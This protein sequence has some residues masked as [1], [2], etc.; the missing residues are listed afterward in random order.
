MNNYK[1]GFCCKYLDDNRNKDKKQLRLTEQLMN[2]KQTTLTALRKLS[3]IDVLDKITQIVQHNCDTLWRQLKWLSSQP[4]QLRLFRITS[5]FVPAYT[6]GEF[7]WVFKHDQFKNII[8]G[9]QNIKQYAD[10]HNIRL[11]SHPGQFTNICSISDYVVDESILELEYHADLA[12][13]MGYGDTWHSSG[14]AIN[15]HANYQQD[16]DLTR[17]KDI[18]LN[19]V[20]STVRNLITLENDEFCCSVDQIISSGIA[21]HVALVLDIHHHFIQSGEYIQSDDIRAKTF[22][23]SWKSIRP[24]MHMSTSSEMILTEH[25]NSVLPDRTLLLADGYNRKDLRSHSYLCWNNAVNHWA[26][27]FL[28]FS[29]I[30]VE[31]KAKNLASKQLYEFYIQSQCN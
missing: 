12:R 4:K 8:N 20:S 21:D 3:S 17:F 28:P 22:F 30:E 24:L 27:S 1:I 16:P 13:Y 18:I 14:F 10:E 26:C 2:Q 7:D 15:I 11:C 31:A 23:S 19:K 9:L 25:S 29:D 6:V 5:N